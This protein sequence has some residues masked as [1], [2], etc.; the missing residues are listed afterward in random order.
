MNNETFDIILA[1]DNLDEAHL[2]IRTLKKNGHERIRHLRDGE[3]FM[4]LIQD[5][6][7]PKPKL[8]LLDLKMPKMDGIE[9]LRLLKSNPAWKSVPVVML[10]SSDSEKDIVESYELG[11]NAYIVKPVST[12]NFKKAI[13][14]IG[15]F[16]I[17]MNRTKHS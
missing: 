3:E 9:V 14:D 2:T 8:I 10:T 4:K 16:W 7:S 5:P 15:V 11:V 1:E 12:D 13:L 17:T 6:A